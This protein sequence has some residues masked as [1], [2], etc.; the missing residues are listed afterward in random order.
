MYLID[1]FP[2]D[3][4]VFRPPAEAFSLIVRLASGCP[5]NRCGFCAMYSRSRFRRAEIEEIVRLIDALPRSVKSE[6]RRIFLGDG[7]P[8]T[9]PI[10]HLEAVLKVLRVA[11][12]R[13]N[14][15]TAY[16]SP[17]SLLAL[18]SK[19]LRRLKD[20]G[21]TAVY[22]GLESG[23]DEVLKL[24][25]KGN[26][27]NEFV[28]ACTLAREA[29]LKVSVTMILGLGGRVLSGVHASG[30]FTAVNRARPNY[31]SVLTLIPGG[32]EK[33]L[34][35][36]GPMTRYELLDELGRIISGIEIDTVFRNDHTSNFIDCNGRLQRDKAKLLSGISAV[37]TQGQNN[38]YL[39]EMPLFLGESSL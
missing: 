10:E 27:A 11:F 13:A 38:T 24:A 25:G 33:F 18:G 4:F 5:H 16:G 12:S 31:F 22:V 14:R 17:G 28:T 6:T 35:T 34:E 32:N 30:T 9:L 19:G 20:L 7:D 36:V 23:S 26:T 21:L 39:S 8:M 29:G 2:D 15:I 3:S 37:M 1:P